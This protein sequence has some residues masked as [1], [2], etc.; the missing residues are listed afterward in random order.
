MREYLQFL[1][2]GSAFTDENNSAFFTDGNELV[3]IDLPMSSFRKLRKYGTDTLS[4]ISSPDITVLVTHTHG[5]HTGGIPT[6][7]HYAFYILHRKV[8]VIAPSE[9]VAA[10]LRFLAERLEGCRP[11]AYDLITA[12]EAARPWLLDVIPTRHSPELEG[13]CF[14][15]RLNVNGQNVVYTGDTAVIEPFLPYLG[16]GSLL[17]S[18][19]SAH[20]SAVHINVSELIEKTD[21]LDIKLYLMHLDDPEKIAE[22]ASGSNALIAPLFEEHLS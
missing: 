14:G 6:F 21:G 22:A 11:E 4:G 18:D 12:K 7:I 9:E 19:S 2:R 16:K 5:D 10:D 8:T 15:Y 13:R 17:Y 3:L 20:D 1:G